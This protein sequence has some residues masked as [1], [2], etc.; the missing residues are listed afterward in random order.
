MKTKA[1]KKGLTA[2]ILRQ[3]ARHAVACIGMQ[4]V[5]IYQARFRRLAGWFVAGFIP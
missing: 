5:K 3:T 1:G 2:P 4:R